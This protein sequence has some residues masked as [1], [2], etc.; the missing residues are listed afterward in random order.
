MT[1]CAETC[2]SIYVLYT[3]D[4][5]HEP[6]HIRCWQHDW[7]LL[8]LTSRS[9]CVVLANRRLLAVT[10]DNVRSVRSHDQ[11]MG[12]GHAKKQ[13]WSM[14]SHVISMFICTHSVINIIWRG[15]FYTVSQKTSHFVIVHIFDKY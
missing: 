2:P 1:V 11:L 4:V 7:K 9:F 5:P 14:N 10:T 3:D 13:S 12:Q 6:H 8:S 15:D